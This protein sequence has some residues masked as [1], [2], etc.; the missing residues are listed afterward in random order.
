M[1]RALNSSLLA[2]LLVLGFG[3]C[4]SQQTPAPKSSG[5]D[6]DAAMAET[7]QQL[8]NSPNSGYLHN[9]LA[10]LAAAKGDW[11]TYD[12]E[13]GTAIQLE[14]KNSL[15]YFQAAEVYRRR[16]MNTKALYMC[17]RASELDPQNPLIHF[18]LGRIYETQSESAKALKEFATSKRLLDELH[19]TRRTD[20]KTYYDKSGNAYTLGDLEN[21]LAKRLSKQ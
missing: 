1:T 3:S 14:P 4:S 7:R 18:E 15:N 17:S 10:T 11:N 12:K 2:A 13:I 6:V 9:Q 21:Q 16:S 8:A 19:S 20:V 5:T